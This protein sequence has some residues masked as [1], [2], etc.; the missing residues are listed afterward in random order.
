MKNRV[1]IFGLGFMFN[2]YNE[3]L[4][5]HYNVI[6]VTDNDNSKRD[7]VALVLKDISIIAPVEIP[8]LEFDEVIIT[9]SSK[10]AILQIKQQLNELGVEDN[11]ICLVEE[12]SFLDDFIEEFY[13]TTIDNYKREFGVN[14]STS[15]SLPLVSQLAR[16]QDIINL[17]CW[18]KPLSCIDLKY[19]PGIFNRKFWEWAFISQAL[20]ER[21]MLFPQKRG[22]GFAC[23][24]EPLPALFAKHGVTITATDL[25]EEHENSLQWKQTG[26]HSASLNALEYPSICDSDIL[27]KNVSFSPVD[28]SNIPSKFYDFD[29]C[30]SSCAFE[31]LDSVEAG[32]Q[33]ILN[34]LKVLKPG[35]VSVHTTEFNLSSKSS[36]D[37]PY[38]NVFGMDFFESLRSEVELQGHKF[39]PFDYRLGNHP[40]EDYVY[41]FTNKSYSSH[42]KLE[43]MTSIVTSIGI[44]IIKR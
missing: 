4:V 9:N 20:Y 2:R 5:E 12:L 1:I 6:S 27:Y 31:H 3:A 44:I 38:M 26:Q 43:L 36:I 21:D 30:W 13:K 7:S 14:E 41:N 18:I 34:S 35:G 22:I 42:F 25:Q 32:R 29:F 37:N 39:M 23:G 15:T 16:R 19:N 28:M 24:Q 10:E 17:D 40:D 33:F 11:R 8:N